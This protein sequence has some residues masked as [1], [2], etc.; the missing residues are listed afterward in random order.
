VPRE[1]ELDRRPLERQHRRGPRVPERGNQGVER[2]R[3]AEA[4]YRFVVLP[5]LAITADGQY[6]GDDLR[7][8]NGPEGSVIGFRATAA[9]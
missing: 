1:Y 9:F 4:Y 5:A 8:V 3:V 2:T 6:M 7:S